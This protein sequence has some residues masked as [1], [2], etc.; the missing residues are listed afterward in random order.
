MAKEP[1]I[2]SYYSTEAEERIEENQ[3]GPTKEKPE[4]FDIEEE[5]AFQVGLI[6]IILL[7]IIAG[8]ITW[9]FIKKNQN[10]KNNQAQTQTQEAEVL[11][12]QEETIPQE[13]APSEATSSPTE[14]S[15]PESQVFGEESSAGA[16][17]TEAS[18]SEGNYTVQIGDTLYG[19][20]QKF[21]VDWKEIA[22]IN[23]LA[24]PYNLTPGEKINI[25]K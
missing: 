6:T 13:T 9:Y 10:T 18:S 12:V 23:N 15:M 5:K 25:P 16:S 19:L 24:E 2:R 8:I 7:V 17:S 21:D 1:V 4:V 14:E 3:P 22:E 11:G 20:G